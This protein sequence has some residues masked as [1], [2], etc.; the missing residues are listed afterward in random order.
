MHTD[1]NRQTH[2]QSWRQTDRHRNTHTDRH[3]YRDTH[4]HLKVLQRHV[5]ITQQVVQ[6]ASEL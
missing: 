1:T 3:T 2:I 4:T 6:A 5:V